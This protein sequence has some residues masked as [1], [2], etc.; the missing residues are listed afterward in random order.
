MSDI[1]LKEFQ[2]MKT[3]LEISLLTTIQEYKETFTNATGIEITKIEISISEGCSN[4][5][6]ENVEVT[7]DLEEK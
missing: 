6:I 1:T 5:G 3:Q 7:V 4:T 2:A